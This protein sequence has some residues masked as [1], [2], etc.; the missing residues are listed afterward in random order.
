MCQKRHLPS[1]KSAITYIDYLETSLTGLIEQ[2]DRPILCVIH[3]HDVLQ[4]VYQK[5]HPF[6]LEKGREILAQGFGGSRE[7]LLKRFILS[8]KA[9]CLALT[10][11]GKV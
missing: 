9:Y 3:S 7:K 5:M 6:M 2:E 1:I 8:E 10:A 11:F 4:K